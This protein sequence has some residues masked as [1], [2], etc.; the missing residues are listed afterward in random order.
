MFV[1]NELKNLVIFYFFI[2][3]CLVLDKLLDSIYI[4]SGRLEFGTSVIFICDIGYLLEGVRILI[5]DINGIWF[6]FSLVCKS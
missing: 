4:S 5:C 6:D 2:V 3:D 1:C